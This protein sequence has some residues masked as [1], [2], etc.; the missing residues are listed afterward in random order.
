MILQAIVADPADLFALN[1]NLD[2][3]ALAECYARTGRVRIYGL[4]AQGAVELHD[5]LRERNDWI[6]VIHADGA[7]IELTRDERITMGAKR[8][9]KIEDGVNRRGREGFQ[10]RYEAL[11]VPDLDE[12]LDPH[13]LLSPFSHFLHSPAML[14][15]IED[16]TARAPHRFINGQA[17]SYGIGDFLTGHDDNASGENRMAAFVLGL[18]QRWRLEWGGL[19]LFH[20]PHERTAEALVPRFN[21][22]DLFHVPQQ[23]SV[24]WVSPSAGFS[25]IAVTGWYSTA[26]S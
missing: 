19:L 25:R 22:L 16:I 21:T 9:A 8:Y 2:R 12:A 15:L 23:H 10:Y 14:E 3:K 1:P 26:Q 5:H 17:T 24:S 7:P 18:T 13:D 20:G 4:L 6:Q 11:R